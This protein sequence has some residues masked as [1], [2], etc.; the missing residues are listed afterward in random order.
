MT[1]SI[2]FEGSFDSCRIELYV[3]NFVWSVIKFFVSLLMVT[4]ELWPVPVAKSNT[5]L[6]LRTKHEKSFDYK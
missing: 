3:K 6:I 5:I 1:F 4:F 2:S